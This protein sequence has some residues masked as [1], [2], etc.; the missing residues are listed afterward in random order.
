MI[1]LVAEQ[2]GPGRET[3]A[4]LLDLAERAI[5]EKGY[6]ATSIEELVVAA[7]ITKSGFFYHFRAKNDVAKALMWRD[8][9]NTAQLFDAIFGAA[10]AD[11][12]DP[13]DALLDGLNRFANAAAISPQPYPGCLV[14]AFAY[15]RELFDAEHWQ[16]MEEGFAER[17][18]Q[19]RTRLERI[20]MHR[21]SSTS[22]DLDDLAD[23]GIAVVQGAIVLDR[24]RGGHVAIGQQI[25]LYGAFLRNLFK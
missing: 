17:H 2:T 8:N 11:N 5:L 22:I 10:D 25:A 15:Q 20:A 3:R 6:A 9:A 4:R 7:G 23:M 14:A 18:A 24:V 1:K 21:P 13:L 19:F 12:A 16:L